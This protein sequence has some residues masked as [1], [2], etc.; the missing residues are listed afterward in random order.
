MMSP[1]RV[2]AVAVALLSF[3]VSPAY[4]VKTRF[5]VDA[6]EDSFARGKMEDVIYTQQT[7]LRLGYAKESLINDAIDVVTSFAVAPDGTVYI[8]TGNQGKVYAVSGERFKIL[9]DLDEPKV[10]CLALDSKGALYIGTSPRGVIYRAAKGR[11]VEKFAQLDAL[12]VWSMVVAPDGSVIAG[13]GDEGR[14]FRITADGKSKQLCD[15]EE[16]HITALIKGPDGA[17][18]AGTEPNGLVLKLSM[19]AYEVFCDTPQG[20]V[21]ALVFGPD[22]ALYVGTADIG[23]SGKR[24]DQESAKRSAIRKAAQGVSTVTRRMGPTASTRKAMVAGPPSAAAAGNF[25]YRVGKAG[26]MQPLA[27]VPGRSIFALAST[28]K[29][30]LIGTGPKGELFRLKD[31]KSDLELIAKFEEKYVNALAVVGD[32][33]LVGTAS[34]GMIFRTL[35]RLAGKGTFVSPVIDGGFPCR[36]GTIEIVGKEA[37][38]ANVVVATRCGNTKDANNPTWSEWV[39]VGSGFGVKA[40][41]KKRRSRF[42][43]YRL[44]FT[45]DGKATAQVGRVEV[46]YL[47][48]NVPPT[49]KMLTVAPLVSPSSKAPPGKGRK[50]TRNTGAFKV[51]WKASDPNGDQLEYRLLFRDVANEKAWKELAKHMRVTSTNWTSEGLPDGYY[52]LKLEVSDEPDNGE[53]ESFTRARVSEP[54]LVDNTPPTVSIKEAKI[55]SDGSVSVKAEL[56]DSYSRIV[57]ALYLVDGGRWKTL[58]PVDGVFDERAEQLDFKTT[59]LEPG[60]HTIFI[61]IRDRKG[62]VS[63]GKKVVTVPPRKK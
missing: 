47:Q 26:V 2:A 49:I 23:R 32:G 20:T 48:A 57:S 9:V 33:V 11:K 1:F 24:A 3:C 30:I 62:N 10:N 61:K 29:G 38:G 39:D 44:T 31:G 59:A 50:P 60:E 28:P 36:W 34:R 35:E 58:S 27:A 18:Y 42:L 12:H 56:S 63:S 4:G 43:Q 5:R 7:G 21:G 55:G 41:G 15:T 17:F 53:E 22:G 25:L 13:T 51:S 6:S 16:R 45:G 46:A 54:F 14:I 52:M 40:A 37:A 8:G 19:S